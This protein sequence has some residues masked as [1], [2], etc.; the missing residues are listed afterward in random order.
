MINSD[1]KNILYTST[2]LKQQSKSKHLKDSLRIQSS[3]KYK[4]I[5]RTTKRGHKIFNNI[6]YQFVTDFLNQIAKSIDV[7]SLQIVELPFQNWDS[8]DQ[9]M[10]DNPFIPEI[11]RDAY[12]QNHNKKKRTFIITDGRRELTVRFLDSHTEFST[13]DHFINLFYRFLA[14]TTLIGPDKESVTLT[15]YPSPFRKEL[16]KKETTKDHSSSG[17]TLETNDTLTF[18]PKNVN[19]GFTY[20]G[21]PHSIYIYREEEFPKVFV[22]E[23]MHAL[24]RDSPNCIKSTKYSLC[25][26]KNLQRDM[27]ETFR[28]SVVTDRNANQLLFSETY[29]E[30]WATIINAILTLETTNLLFQ[31]SSQGNGQ[32][33]T[34]PKVHLKRIIQNLENEK[35]WAVK[36]AARILKL[37]GF[38]NLQEFFVDNK[39]NHSQLNVSEGSDIQKRP[40]DESNMLIQHTAVFEYYILR[41][42]V[43]FQLET[44]INCCYFD[45]CVE[46]DK[47]KFTVSIAL[48]V[49][50]NN[51]KYRR[52]LN[53]YIA[54][55]GILR[56]KTMK[57]T[58]T[59]ISSF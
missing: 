28:V 55:K 31:S 23:M 50:Q 27:L 22:H 37:S 18:Q 17:K 32:P 57:M 8:D 9:E 3:K 34:I 2:T 16:P 1:T 39:F 5:H 11:V 43:L 19:S 7:E 10:N 49:L 26:W 58:H 21:Q 59:K 30:T 38:S 24:D 54:Q 13:N 14:V 29:A 56:Q 36:Q 15:F 53:Q 47:T 25:E 12:N 51:K 42:A 52:L 20:H 33:P 35:V 48:D 6:I 4:D 45:N 44:F 46:N 41:S 40:H